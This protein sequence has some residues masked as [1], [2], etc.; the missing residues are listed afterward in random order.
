MSDFSVRLLRSDEERAATDLFRRALHIKEMTDEE[1]SAISGSRQPDRAFGAFDPELIGTARSFDSEVTLPGGGTTPLAA[2]SLVGV[3]G[4]RTRRGVLT[5]LMRAQF[6]DFAARGVPAAMLHA[7]EGTIYG[8]FGYGIGAR[9]KSFEVDRQRA[10]FRPEVPVGGEISLLD[11]ESTIEQWPSLFDALPRIRPGMIARSPHLWPGY[12]R[13]VRRAT[14][15]VATA[16]HRGPDG[17]DGYV[18]YTV[19]RTKF[20]APAVLKI[21][22][23]HHS[24]SDAFA[25][26]WRYLLSVDLVDRI[27]AEKRPLDEPVELLF[28]DPRHVTV[29]KVQDEGWLRLVDVATMLDARTYQGEPVVI[30]VTDPFLEHNSGRYRLS[31]DG[32]ARTTDPADL[33]LGVDTLSMLY[34]GAW[35]ASDLAAA[36]RVRATGEAALLRADLLFGTRVNPWCGTFF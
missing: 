15:P 20:G 33:E 10:R 16:V 4:D 31:A 1:W 28:T 7:S 2:V 26:L 14:T 13:E 36:G 34:L 12:E 8:R 23:F 18:T 29:E 3:R 27:T 35:R 5:G 25:G 19:E 30:E 6:E 22:S 32:A 9:A 17:I 11:L 21:Q 24:G